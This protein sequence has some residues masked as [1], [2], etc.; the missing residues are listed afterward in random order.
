MCGGGCCGLLPSKRTIHSEI[1]VSLVCSNSGIDSP[2]LKVKHFGPLGWSQ[3]I[4]CKSGGIVTARIPSLGVQ[5]K[6]K[7]YQVLSAAG[8]KREHCSSDKLCMFSVKST[9]L[10]I[11]SRF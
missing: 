2:K 10:R 1:Q 8:V 4:P 6:L 11:A 9:H 7:L 3:K 5:E